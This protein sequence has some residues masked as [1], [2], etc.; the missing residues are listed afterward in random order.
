MPLIP[1]LEAEEGSVSSRPAWS[2]YQVPGQ[3]RL[4]S[5][6]MSQKKQNK[7][8]KKKQDYSV[9]HHYYIK[10]PGCDL[11]PWFSIH[12]NKYLTLNL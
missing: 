4:H 11:N 9:E 12:L 1:A 3:Q 5:E 6:A 2:T 7:Q 8:T 10:K